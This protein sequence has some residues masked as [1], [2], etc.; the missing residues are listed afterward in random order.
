MKKK[1]LTLILATVSVAA[2]CALTLTACS[3]NIKKVNID[4]HES[5][6]FT[7]S[8]K[9]MELT[10]STTVYD[11]LL[12]LQDN[13][14]ITFDGNGTD[15]GYYITSINSTEE[16]SSYNEDYSHGE[17]TYW[18]V[19]FDFITL[20]GDEAI[21]GSDEQTCE[22]NGKT[23]YYSN[24]YVSNVPCVEGHTYAFV[25]ESWSY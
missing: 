13:G 1:L 25:Y 17:G 5:Y 20:D 4:D 19:Y 7:A 21:Y 8:S 16:T 10:D 23:L 22:Y 14:D 11:Y 3:G 12:A 2:V 24:Y 9:V 18:A 6:V 15:W